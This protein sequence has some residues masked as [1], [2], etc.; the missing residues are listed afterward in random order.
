MFVTI[1]NDC[2]DGNAMGKQMTRCAGLF[3]GA[4]IATV[5][6][7]QDELEAAGNLVDMLDTSD[8]NEGVILVNVA[9]RQGRGKKWPNGTPF[10]YFTYQN[11]LIVSTIAE[12]SLSLVKKLGLADSLYLTDVPTV[13]DA[14]I[15]KGELDKDLRELIIKTQFRSCDYMPRLAYWVKKGIDVPSETYSFTNVME[16][17]KAV[18]WVDNFGNC[19]T[20]ILPEEVGHTPGKKLMT[21]VGEIMCYERL[22]DIPNDEAG[23]IIGSSGIGQKRFLELDVQGKSSAAKFNLKPGSQLF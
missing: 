16:A 21:K 17:P 4:S 20:T 5:A 23:L 12:M 11:T 3:P 18:W 15:Q 14:M 2:H 22:K 9:P 7:E 8:G 1:I 19:K 13:V 10:G 6:I